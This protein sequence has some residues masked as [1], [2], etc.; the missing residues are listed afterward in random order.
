MMT[1]VLDPDALIRLQ[2]LLRARTGLTFP[3]RRLADPRAGL[4]RAMAR[5][6]AADF[7]DFAQ[8]LDADQAAFDALI[9]DITVGETYFFRE[10]QQF[11]VL[12]RLVLP[13]LRRHL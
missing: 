1:G 11:A 4:E 6:G 5:T 9:A 12:R 2:N 13:E 10:P 7:D 8:R 3:E